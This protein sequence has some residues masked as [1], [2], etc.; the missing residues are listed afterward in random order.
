MIEGGDVYRVLSAMVP[1]FVA[2]GLGFGSV[3]WW[4]ILTI[5]QCAGINK[6]VALIAVPALGFKIIA[7][8]NLYHINYQYILADLVSKL[9]MLALLA[10]WARYL[11]PRMAPKS[12]PPGWAYNWAVT[13]FMVASLPN[14]LI[15]AYPFLGLS[16][17]PTLGPLNHSRLLALGPTANPNPN[18]AVWYLFLI[19][20]FDLRAAH[21]HSF[22]IVSMRHLSSL[23][24]VN[25]A[26]PRSA[27]LPPP[28]TVSPVDRL[29]PRS[30][31]DLTLQGQEGQ[32]GQGGQE[33][34][35]GQ[36]GQ[37]AIAVKVSTS[38]GDAGSPHLRNGTSPASNSAPHGALAAA[39]AGLPGPVTNGIHADSKLPPTSSPAAAEVQPAGGGRSQVTMTPSNGHLGASDTPGIVSGM[40]GDTAHA[41]DATWQECR[42]LAPSLS[43]KERQTVWRLTAHI[44]A[45]KVVTNPNFGA[46][47]LG[48][49]YSF[50]SFGVGFDMPVLLHNSITIVSNTGLGMA[51][52]SLGTFMAT[53]NRWLPC[54][55]W[56]TAWTFALKFLATPALTAGCAVALTL[57]GDVL[58]IAAVQAAL[59]QGIVGFVFAKE[60]NVHPEVLCTG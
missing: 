21:Q 23:P 22:R 32:E 25:G 16:D 6:F 36:K 47:V 28:G 41:E 5:E 43:K 3:R 35:E 13:T 18:V 56:V 26:G 42:Q 39:T 48:G 46:V 11:A 60:Y 34:Q 53:Q 40:P 19:A 51:M 49:F 2:L 27:A 52:F 55:A 45:R 30:G 10:L 37:A 4:N 15:V 38:S 54:G 33:G 17:S 8:T 57:K 31:E 12:A 58:K 20:L 44:L 1:L 59:P 29:A 50:L 9:L 14:T 24:R 7:E